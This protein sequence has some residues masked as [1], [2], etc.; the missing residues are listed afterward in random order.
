[1]TIT[2]EQGDYLPLICIRA[3]RA[4]ELIY[5]ELIRKEQEA[6]R[7]AMLEARR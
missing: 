2:I 6:D 4:D 5:R 7:R 3:F 1:M